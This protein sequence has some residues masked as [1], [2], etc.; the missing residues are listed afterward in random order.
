MTAAAAT[1]NFWR[2]RTPLVK[3][4]RVC[5]VVFAGPHFHA[6]L[7]LTRDLLHQRQL[8][9]AVHVVHAPTDAQLLQCAPTADVALPFM[10]RFDA[11][12]L[13]AA[14]RL[15]L[16]QQFGV[17]LEGVDLKAAT[18]L[19]IAVSNI[20]AAGTGNAEA[21]AE[22]ALLLSLNLMRQTATELPRRF[23]A[24]QLGGLPIP[25][26]IFG[27][28][29]TVVGFGAV[30]S[31]VCEYF[32]A[33]GANVTAVRR[34]WSR[35]TTITSLPVQQSTCLREALPTTDLLILAC[36]M[37]PETRHLMNA[38]T[39][40]LLPTTA[41]V[42]NIGRGPLVEY[43]ALLQPVQENRIAGFASDVGV[44]HGDKPSEPWD[45][46]DALSKHPHTIFTP[47]VGGYTDHSYGLM[48]ETVVDNLERV[49][50]RG[51]PPS[52]WVN[53]DATFA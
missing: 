26:S 37:T 12:F 7:G 21:T 25:R 3:Q 1:T 51:E 27:K 10:Q 52:P 48:V 15:R 38:Q 18:E 29:V 11:T 8:Q 34:D 13:S 31:K 41:C 39:L 53:G 9:D 17:G 43:H 4:N 33:L 2:F 6:A 30:G 16:V 45:P 14:P 19:G 5:R 28:N 32:C 46:D 47:H 24:R 23:R 35:A 49:A 40:S 22:H 50:L 44:G 36:T 20:P 42:V